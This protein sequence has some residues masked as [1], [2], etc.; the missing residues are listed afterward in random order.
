MTEC[1]AFKFQ[2]VATV[3]GPALIVVAAGTMPVPVVRGAVVPL[4]LVPTTPGLHYLRMAEEGMVSANQA[5]GGCCVP[6]E[7]LRPPRD[8]A[9]CT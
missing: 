7:V 1:P 4:L 8:A 9:P 5:K 3:W 6:H 2:A